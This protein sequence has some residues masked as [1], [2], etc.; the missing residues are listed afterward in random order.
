MEGIFDAM[1]AGTFLYIAVVDILI[2]EFRSTHLGWLFLS[3]LFGFSIMAVVAVW[4]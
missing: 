3:T 2:D 4:S 1:A